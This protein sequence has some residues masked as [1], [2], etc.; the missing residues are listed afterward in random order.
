MNAKASLQVK[1]AVRA[2][3]K[4]GPLLLSPLVVWLGSEG[5]D[6]TGRMFEVGGGRLSV[7]DGWQHGP[8]IG[9]GQR[10]FEVAAI[11]GAVHT[12]IDAAPA[13]AP[14]YGAES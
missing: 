4:E 1:G 13:P 10:R 14:V 9:V 8:E 12:S 7:C 11:A 2:Y 6:V 3:R 5:C